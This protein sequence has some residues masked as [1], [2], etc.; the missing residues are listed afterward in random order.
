[1]LLRLASGSFR[2][3]NRSDGPAALSRLLLWATCSTAGCGCTLKRIG[4]DVSEKLDYV[5]GVF[6]VERH[7]SVLDRAGLE[8]RACECYAALNRE[9][10]RLLAS[11][12]STKG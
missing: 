1:M 2:E 10:G 8:H 6:T 9:Q 11:T 4:E 12:P 5:P 3:A 7:I